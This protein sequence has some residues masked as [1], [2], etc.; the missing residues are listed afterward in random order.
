[1]TGIRVLRRTRLDFGKTSRAFSS[2]SRPTLTSLEAYAP[3]SL[4]ERLIGKTLMILEAESSQLLKARLMLANYSK[5]SATLDLI[6]PKGCLSFEETLPKD[7]L[8]CT[9]LSKTALLRK[10][11]TMT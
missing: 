8:K 10:L 1:M 2:K 6:I 11:I 5:L 4:V 7:Y 9:L 3:T